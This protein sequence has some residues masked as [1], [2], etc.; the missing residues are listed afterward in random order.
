MTRVTC[1]ARGDLDVVQE[2]TLATRTF[3][4]TIEHAPSCPHP[5]GKGGRSRRRRSMRRRKPTTTTT[6]TKGNRGRIAAEEGGGRRN[7]PVQIH[8]VARGCAAR[9]HRLTTILGV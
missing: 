8:V 7:G 5:P 6:T 2:D 1:A 3:L 9:D 4:A